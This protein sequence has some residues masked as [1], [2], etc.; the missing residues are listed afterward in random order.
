[1]PE[2]AGEANTI[3]T[4]KPE[5]TRRPMLEHDAQATAVHQLG[6]LHIVS[7]SRLWDDMSGDQLF[8]DVSSFKLYESSCPCACLKCSFFLL[9]NEHKDDGT[10]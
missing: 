2:H 1:M 3:P 4:W 10:L 6:H 5:L 7:S 8:K 9:E